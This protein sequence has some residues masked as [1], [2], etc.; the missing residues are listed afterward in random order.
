MYSITVDFCVLLDNLTQREKWT[1]TIKKAFIFVGPSVVN[2]YIWA[3]F[4]QNKYYLDF[5]NN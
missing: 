2:Y 3:N 5:G 1:T 4:I